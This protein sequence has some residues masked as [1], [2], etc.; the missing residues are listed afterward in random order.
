MGGGPVVSGFPAPVTLASSHFL[1]SPLAILPLNPKHTLTGTPEVHI[2]IVFLSK[3]ASAFFL[4]GINSELETI[5]LGSCSL[6]VNV[7]MHP[8]KIPAPALEDT[9]VFSS[10]ASLLQRIWSQAYFITC[11]F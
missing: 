9:S 10:P 4:Q 8:L 1:L 11:F 6:S 5:G 3:E 2:S 7:K